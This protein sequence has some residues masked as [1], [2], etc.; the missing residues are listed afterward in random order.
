M[1]TK[2]NRRRKSVKPLL[3]TSVPSPC[4]GVCWL[5]NQTGWCE[6]CW[7]SGDE[8][9]DWLIMTREQKLQLLQVL[10]QRQ[11]KV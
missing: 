10:E 6:G 11:T 7:R 2:P 3:D 1:D 9:R 8:I 4:I 5:N